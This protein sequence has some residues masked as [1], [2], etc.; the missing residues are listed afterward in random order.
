MFCSENF[1]SSVHLPVI[2]SNQ[3]TETI[4]T[5]VTILLIGFFLF[6][7]VPVWEWNHAKRM[8]STELVFWL[9]NKIPQLSSKISLWIGTAIFSASSDI[10]NRECHVWLSTKHVP[11]AI[12]PAQFPIVYIRNA[13]INLARIR[14]ASWL[15]DKYASIYAVDS[16]TMNIQM[17]T[18]DTTRRKIREMSQLTIPSSAYC[19]NDRSSIVPQS[20][21]S[22]RTDM[23]AQSNEKCVFQPSQ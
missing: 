22:S 4:W 17:L 16:A 11:A 18:I 2:I 9:E 13:R 3:P 15:S 14:R 6:L 5:F 21:K 1:A 19:Q 10:D 20:G 12:A 23:I 7:T 8:Y